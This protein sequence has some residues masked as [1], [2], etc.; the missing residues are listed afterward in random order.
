MSLTPRPRFPGAVKTAAVVILL[1][2]IGGGAAYAIAGKLAPRTPVTSSSVPAATPTPSATACSAPPPSPRPV[3]QLTGTPPPSAGTGWVNNPLGVNLRSSPSAS[4]GKVTTLSQGTSVRVT[5]QTAD[6]SGNHW[7]SV[8]TGSQSGWVRDDLL[9]FSAI[10]PVS[11]EGFSLMIP[12]DDTWTTQS[13]ITDVSRPG[14]PLLPFLRIQTS[15]TDTLGVQLPTV[16]RSDVPAISDHTAVIQVWSYT[17]LERVTRA[18]LDAC[19]VKEAYS[20]PD[21]GWPYVTSVLVH[22]PGRS[23][24]F[25]F[26]TATP[27]DPAV[28]QVLDSVATV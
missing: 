21:G 17:V 10:K 18:A 6:A 24:S 22:A 26:F 25:T 4:A 14:D 9:V 1:M 11:G 3:V 8:S 7:D 28:Q 20:R 23:Y 19:Q 27:A 2:A 15:T 16:L 5:G 12:S 13:G